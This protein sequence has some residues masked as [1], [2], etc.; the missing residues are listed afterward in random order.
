MEFDGNTYINEGIRMD[1]LMAKQIYEEIYLHIELSN[2]DIFLCGGAS[3]RTNISK[4]DQLRE[5]LEKN[6]KISIFYPEEMFMEFLNR[7]KYDL[8]TLESFLA[9]NSDLI[10]IVCES[11][12]SFAELGA[13]VNNERTLN[14]VV[15]LIQKKYK[16]AKSFIRQGPV[17]HVELH[18]KENV[19]YF[20]DDMDD[21]VRE[22]NQ[23][24]D[25]KYWFYRS[26]KY[27]EYA[28][29]TKDINLISGQFYFILLL[30]YFDNKIDI[31]QMPT[32]V[33]E[34]YYERNFRADSF[35]I[36]YKAALKRLYKEGMLLKSFENGENFYRLTEKGYF[37]AKTLLNDV[38]I[39]ERD[40]TVNKIRMKILQAQ[41]C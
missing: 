31:K 28:P 41:Y 35:E 4:R 19:I 16:K 21:M 12:G 25:K 5:Q 17:Q 30:L 32:I 14:K 23:F 26:K 29:K 33:R 20:N 9:D 11:P 38:N 39:A 3:G 22:V 37:R 6:K 8:L 7:K 15:V 10:L 40:H 24:I 18:N 13:F 36:L 1:V 34:I 27:Q 2:I